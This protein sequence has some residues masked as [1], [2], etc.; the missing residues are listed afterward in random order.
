MA[1]RLESSIEGTVTC[2]QFDFTGKR[3]AVSYSESCIKIFG[4]VENSLIEL[5]TL[6]NHLGEVF[7]L[8]WS[9]PKYGSLLASCG[10]DRKVVVM[11]EQSIRTWSFFYE[12]VDPVIINCISWAP[13]ELGLKLLAGLEDGNIMI[14][15]YK[16]DWKNFKFS[17]HPCA[18]KVA[19]WGNALSIVGSPNPGIEKLTRFVTGDSDGKIKCW[20][21]I[22]CWSQEENT[23][24]SESLEKHVGCIRDISW[25]PVLSSNREII[26]SCADRTVLIWYRSSEEPVW[27][28]KSPLSFSAPVWKVSWDIQG[29]CLA[30][31]AADNI[32]RIIREDADENFKVVTQIKQNGEIINSEN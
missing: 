26:A 13:W 8:S 23:F 27:K 18:I 7:S 6:Q 4:Y 22:K 28:I 31:S 20:T 12:Y 24:E 11:K 2:A 5:C 25:N 3:L 29:N 14:F 9:H 32:T 1:I 10:S 21:Q 17:G 16:D 30:V 15:V 19:V